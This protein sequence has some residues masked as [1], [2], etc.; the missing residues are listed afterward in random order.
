MKYR[1]RPIQSYCRLCER[2]FCY[3]QI[4][5]TRL[6]CSPCVEI[7]RGLHNF[8]LRERRVTLKSQERAA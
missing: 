5:N 6:L 1:G 3:F 7:E 4:T 8:F 2:L